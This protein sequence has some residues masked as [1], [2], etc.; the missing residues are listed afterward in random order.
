MGGL[1]G[2]W[3]GS[4]LDTLDALCGVPTYLPPIRCTVGRYLFR[5]QDVGYR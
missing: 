2:G 5:Y 1:L 4:G 3:M